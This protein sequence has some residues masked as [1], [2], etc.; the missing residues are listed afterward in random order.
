MI[1]LRDDVELKDTLVVAIPK[2]KSNGYILNTIRIKY[3]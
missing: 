2:I 3:E 1:D